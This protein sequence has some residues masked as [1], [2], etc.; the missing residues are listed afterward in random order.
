MLETLFDI[1]L[2]IL[3][4]LELLVYILSEFVIELRQLFLFNRLDADFYFTG[5][6]GKIG[7]LEIFR[8]LF[9]ISFSSPFF[10]PMSSSSIL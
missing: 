10:S 5:R 6:P 4:G 7:H 8:K 1:G 3:E 9:S 2:E